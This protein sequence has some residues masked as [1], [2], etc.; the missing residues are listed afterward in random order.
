MIW[1]SVIS[2]QT[3]ALHRVIGGTNLIFI[4]IFAQA[5]HFVTMSLVT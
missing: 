1:R 3:N 2:F 4:I 5:K